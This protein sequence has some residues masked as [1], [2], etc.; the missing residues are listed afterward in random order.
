MPHADSLLAFEPDGVEDLAALRAREARFRWLVENASDL[1]RIVDAGGIVRYDS[2]SVQ[3]VLGLLPTET[4][5]T[6]LLDLVHPDD[7]DL[8]RRSLA[9]IL[10]HPGAV[11]TTE[12]R[13]RH[14]NGEWRVIEATSTNALHD[15]D[16]AGFVV[17]ARDVTQR[18]QTE[19]T[20]ARYAAELR[21]LSL[22]DELTGLYNRRGFLTL[23]GERSRIARRMRSRFA[24]LFLDVDQM[25]PINDRFG[26]AAGDQ[27][28]RE[29]AH[30]LRDT[31]RE[32]DL[33]ARI[34]GDEFAVLAV[35]HDERDTA[36][37]L[38]RIER[39]VAE[40]RLAAELPHELTVSTGVISYDPDH[41]T[42][43]SDLLAEADSRMYAAKEARRLAR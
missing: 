13:M 11:N 16:I 37:L 43:L 36:G 17:T 9:E 18:R 22:R 27:A 33:A 2:R 10:H 40:R 29:I 35:V 19:E 38:R 41:P 25:K 21:A 42:R 5:G 4:T 20:L 6:H 3:R 8:A 30:A 12:Y 31:V 26:H 1:I 14:R 28:L 32:S 34:G 15:P 23:A 24:L 7:R 39:R